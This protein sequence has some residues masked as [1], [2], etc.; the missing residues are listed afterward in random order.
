MQTISLLG[1]TGSIG[2]STLK[3][4]RLQPQRFQ[5]FAATAHSRVGELLQICVEFSPQFAVVANQQQVSWLQAELQTRGVATQVVSEAQGGLEMVA[6]HPDVDQVM[7]AIVGFAGLLPTLA[8]VKA[9]KRVLLANKEALVTSGRLFMQAVADSGAELLPIDSEHNAIFQCLPSRWQQ[10][11]SGSLHAQGISKILL[12]GSGGPFRD[13]P[14]TQFETITPEQACAHP[15][16]SMGRKISVDSAT[17]MNK[18]LEFIEAKWLFDVE[19]EQIDVVIHPQ[20]VIHSMVSYCD[21]SVLAQLGQPD[22]CTPIAHAMCF[23]ERGDAGVKALDFFELAQ[24]SFVKPD[25]NRYPCLGLAIDA[26]RSGQEATTRLNAANEV[27][28][29]AFLDQQIAYTDIVHINEAALRFSSAAEV[30]SIDDVVA[31]DTDARAK[32]LEAV[33]TCR[34]ARR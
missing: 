2:D 9:G 27:A 6:A 23:P 17:M 14:L 28:V 20:S 5:L 34:S 21:G 12:T 15:N 18:G 7:A 10:Q 25:F 26:C 3:V 24:L 19:P 31:I 11:R 1:A 22:M 16:W 33:Q 4:M 32:A 13:T 30:N 8:A 29:A